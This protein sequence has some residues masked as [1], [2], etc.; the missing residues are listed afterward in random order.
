MVPHIGKADA[1]RNADHPCARGQQR[2]LAYAEPTSGGKNAARAKIRRVGE[3][4]IGVV[5]DCVANDSIELQDC[6][7]RIHCVGN[8]LSRERDD[9]R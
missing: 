3:I 7:V 2:G 5:D 9:L 6:G 1:R 4:D 8:R